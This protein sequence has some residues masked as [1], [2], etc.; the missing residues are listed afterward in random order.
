MA[1]TDNILSYWKLDNSM[2]DELNANNGT[3]SGTADVAG[4]INRGRD[5]EQSESDYIDVGSAT[6]DLTDG[7]FTI[8][9]WIY[10]ETIAGVAGGTGILA[11]TTTNAYGFYINDDG[12]LT[13][14]KIGINETIS[15]LTCSTGAWIMATIVYDGVNNQLRFYKNATADGSNP[16]S[17]SSTFNAGITYRIGCV[18]A[19]GYQ[20]GIIDEVGVWTRVLS[21]TEIT[22]LYNSGA[23]LTYPFSADKTVTPSALTLSTTSQSPLYLITISKNNLSL[24]LALK[25]PTVLK[26]RDFFYKSISKNFPVPYKIRMKL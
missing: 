7:D 2:A 21:A 20:D 12:K 25:S 19:S 3:D 13:L 22:E 5:F 17:Y 1:L 4:I 10:L 6:I 15:N 11:G 8:N 24:S 14:G 23:G 18:G 9:A 16:F 26:V